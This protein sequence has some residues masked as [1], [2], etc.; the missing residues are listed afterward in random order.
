MTDKKPLERCYRCG[1]PIKPG[2]AVSLELNTNTG[3]FSSKG[4]I[5][6]DESQGWFD[7]GPECGPKSDGQAV[8]M[9]QRNPREGR[10]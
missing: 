7:F 9:F 8:A 1:R 6:A 3:I 2:A 4:D 10:R 5:P